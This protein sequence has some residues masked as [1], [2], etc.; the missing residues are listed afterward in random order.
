MKKLIIVSLALITFAPLVFAQCQQCQKNGQSQQTQTG[1]QTQTEQQ[2]QNQGEE[3]E[4]MI[5]QMNEIK[6]RVQQKQQEMEQEMQ[7]MGE[8]EQ[9]VY[10]NQNQVR[11]AVHSLLEMKDVLEGIGPQ[12]SAIAQE[13]NNSVQATIRAEERIQTRNT[14]V[15]FFAGGDRESAETIE[16]E[17]VRNKER[18]QQL[19]QL[20]EQCDCHEEVKTM[21][22]E[23]IQQMEQEQN[24]LQ[25]LA[26]NE[27]QYEWLLGRFFNWLKGLF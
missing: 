24:R 7:S 15:R 9:K 4:L 27:K 8:K 21:F 16:Q 25:Q 17:V 20:R 5:Q 6:Q 2:T 18:I 11:V 12:V 23:Q 1:Q 19:Q 26:Q 10:K 13:F 3:N 22:Q 14:I